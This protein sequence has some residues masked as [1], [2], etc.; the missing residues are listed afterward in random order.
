MADPKMAMPEGTPPAMDMPPRPAL[1]TTTLLDAD[2]DMGQVIADIWR[3]KFLILA[4]TAIATLIAL[5]L[6]LATPKTYRAD[7]LL[8]LEETGKMSLPSSL[9]ELAAGGGAPQTGAE[10]EILLSRMVLG[11]AVRQAGLKYAVA[12]KIPSKLTGALIRIGAPN[13]YPTEDERASIAILEVPSEWVGDPITLTTR[14]GGAFDL[15]LPDETTAA[16]QVGQP[17]S[18]PDRSFTLQL[19]SLT[20]APGKEF[21]VTLRSEAEVMRT[22]REMIKIGERGRQ[23]SLIELALD[24]PSP[25]QA[26]ATLTAVIASYID[27][28]PT[29]SEEKAQQSLEFIESQ[30]APAEASIQ[31][32]EEELIRYQ[33][34]SKAIDVKFDTEYLLKELAAVEKLLEGDL[35]PRERD[36]LTDVRNDLL[37]RARALPVTQQQ[38]LNLTRDLEIAQEIYVQL[39]NR[40][41]EMRVMRA[42][43]R[44]EVRLIDPAFASHDPVAP[45][46][47]LIVAPGHRCR[48]VPG[49]QRGDLPHTVRTPPRDHRLRRPSHNAGR[50]IRM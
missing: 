42:S 27:T 11:E 40:V 32:A 24:G 44:S 10:I 19:D 17:V 28:K 38:I 9:T 21:V 39:M 35:I 31:R 36:R 47:T 48:S 29:Y 1:V 18:L 2:L 20:A 34:E 8:Q 50:G 7:A 41:Q 12:P 49:H 23:T 45:Q 43:A 3:Q 4:V 16:G 22:L 25:A 15:T 13:P 37:T 33:R 6:A 46:R 14:E 30:I 26:Q 5:V